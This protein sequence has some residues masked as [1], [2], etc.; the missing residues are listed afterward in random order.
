MTDARKYF[1]SLYGEALCSSAVFSVEGELIF[2]NDQWQKAPFNNV[3][4][5]GQ[6][7]Q[8]R[9]D[10]L[11]RRCGQRTAVCV[12]EKEWRLFIAPC[13]CEGVAYFL[14]QGEDMN[15]YTERE[16]VL[17]L[18]K[19]SNARLSSYLNSIYIV[20]QLL[21]LETKEGKILG[22]EVRHIVRLRDHL[23]QLLDRSGTEDYVLPIELGSFLNNFVRAVNE[24]RP[25]MAIQIE[26]IEKRLVVD[27]MPENVEAVL[28]A[29]VSNAYRFGDGQISV[30]AAREGEDIVVCVWDEGKVVEE[31]RLF[32][33]GYLLPDK[34]GA[35]G[36]GNSLAMAKKLMQIQGGDL[37]YERINDRTCFKLIFRPAAISKEA[38]LA[39]WPMEDLSNTLSRLH[40]ELSDVN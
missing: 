28:C 5:F 18:I 27:M 22:R 10:C 38:V 17:R 23:Y 6:T 33:W 2:H 4:L 16:N 12:D 36:L 31:S 7:E 13:F 35:K 24:L 32:E 14:F 37:V 26:P 9:S 39:E 8:V 20:A 40:I 29:L 3:D 19:A 11:A 25:A 15:L 34:T 21:G 30:S 1:T